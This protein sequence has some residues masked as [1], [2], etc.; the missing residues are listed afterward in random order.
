MHLIIQTT[1]SNVPKTTYLSNISFHTDVYKQ[2][3]VTFLQF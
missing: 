2:S 1:N 3:H